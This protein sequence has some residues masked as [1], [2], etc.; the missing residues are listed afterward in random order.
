MFSSI[1]LWIFGV[2]AATLITAGAIFIWQYNSNLNRIEELEAQTIS[3]ALV[4]S[5]QE[6]NIAILESKA[7][8]MN[9]LL[10]GLNDLAT[11]A[12]Q[13]VSELEARLRN[14]NLSNVD[15]N[16]A[17]TI[18]NQEWADMQTC[19]EI[20]SGKEGKE[21]EENSYCS[22]SLIGIDDDGVRNNEN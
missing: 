22:N 13:K 10:Q 2:L 18:I 5:S 12:S 3:Q 6:V 15:A 16:E 1:K 19:I 11:E 17:E 4:I 8:L 7:A 9:E 21:N 14:R 20:A